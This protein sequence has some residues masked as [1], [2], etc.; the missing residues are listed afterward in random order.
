MFVSLS[1]KQTQKNPNLTDWDFGFYRDD[2]T[3]SFPQNAFGNAEYLQFPQN[4]SFGHSDKDAVQL[5]DLNFLG[6]CLVL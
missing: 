2:F 4:S 3:H 5:L 1:R 6:G